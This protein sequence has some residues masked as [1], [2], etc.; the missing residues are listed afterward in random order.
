MAPDP[1][2]GTEVIDAYDTTLGEFLANVPLDFPPGLAGLS[3]DDP[4][5]QPF[6]TA[7]GGT[8]LKALGPAPTETTWNDALIGSG[9]GT[10]GISAD[11]PMPSWQKGTGVVSNLSSNVPCGGSP[12]TH[13]REVP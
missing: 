6:M 4:A 1:S 9:A 2:T 8:S 12:G 11:W 5:T 7:V 10:G 3:P 13:C